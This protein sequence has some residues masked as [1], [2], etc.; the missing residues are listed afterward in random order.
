MYSSLFRHATAFLFCH[1]T[2]IYLFL[3]PADLGIVW[4]SEWGKIW[5]IIFSTAMQVLPR[6]G[7]Q[8]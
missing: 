6:S 4:E 2:L 8:G 3:K 1:S 5:G 7:K